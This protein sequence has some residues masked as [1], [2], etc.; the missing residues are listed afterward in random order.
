MNRIE[1]QGH[2]GARWARPENTLPAFKYALDAKVDTL[3]LDTLV[4]KDDQVVVV[5]DPILN[6]EICL[7]QHGHQIA[8]SIKV[9][10]LTLAELKKFDCGSKT[11][12][13]FK[14]QVS[15][16]R[17]TIPTLDEFF[18]YVA[19]HPHGKLVK[20]NIEAKSEEDH[21]EYAPSPKDF[22]RLLLALIKKYDA[23]KRTTLQS[24]DHRILKAIRDQDPEITL[25][26]L[27]EHRP[28]E[29]LAVMAKR[30]KTQIVSPDYQW[31]T[32]QDIDD[33]HKAGVRCI[34]WTLNNPKDWD[35]F[36][37]LGV[38][39]IITDNPKDLLLKLGR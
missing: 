12:P 34:P 11:H 21:P 24:F 1:V 37:S 19:Q 33:L 15:V 26:A 4:T 5:H 8:G 9:R 22:S 13:K 2:R 39:G 23:Q 29:N 30:L 20:F 27:I 17:T 10:D 32:K 3:E 16:P 6:P 35:K 18:L 14:H 7:D 38:D 25:S 36:I 28:E 31:L